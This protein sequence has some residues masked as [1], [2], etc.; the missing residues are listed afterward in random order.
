[1]FNAEIP[2][3]LPP[4]DQNLRQFLG[5]LKNPIH[6]HDRTTR[7]KRIL[8]PEGQNKMHHS[9]EAKVNLLGN[10][11]LTPFKVKANF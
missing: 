8:W 10:Y 3:P 7:S 1:V 6:D 4:S 11:P 5:L 2:T 9:N